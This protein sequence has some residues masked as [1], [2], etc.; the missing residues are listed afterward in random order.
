MHEQR[1]AS[2]TVIVSTSPPEIVLPKDISEPLGLHIQQHIP[3]EDGASGSG[4]DINLSPA[5]NAAHLEDGPNVGPSIEHQF[6]PSF[7]ENSLFNTSERRRRVVSENLSALKS[8]P[9]EDLG[10]GLQLGDNEP[11]RRKSEPLS[12]SVDEEGKS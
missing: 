7:N 12:P 8:W 10:F 5:E 3:L 2:A 9:D 4:P 11:K 1:A 6:I